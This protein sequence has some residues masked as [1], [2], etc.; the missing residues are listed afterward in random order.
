MRTFGMTLGCVACLLAWASPGRA[1]WLDITPNQPAEYDFTRVDQGWSEQDRARF[2]STSGGSI[3]LPCIW[4]LALEQKDNLDLLVADHNVAQ[5]HLVPTK[6]VGRPTGAEDG[7]ASGCNGVRL[8]VGIAVTVIHD[9]AS[10]Y[11]RLGAKWVGLNCAFCH[12]GVMHYT[13]EL[14]STYS[15]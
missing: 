13:K 8:P 6:W 2:Y 7:A 4:F 11:R 15:V 12:T 10:P 9:P 14:P 3:L 1:E 5:L